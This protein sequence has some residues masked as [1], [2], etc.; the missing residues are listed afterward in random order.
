MRARA[1]LCALA[2]L[3][4]VAIG[5]AAQ[6]NM[7]DRFLL[8]SG[9][10]FGSVPLETDTSDEAGRVVDSDAAVAESPT[11]N[12]NVGRETVDSDDDGGMMAASKTPTV[13]VNLDDDLEPSAIAAVSEFFFKEFLKPGISDFTLE[14]LGNGEG[15]DPGL[16]IGGNAYG[17]A[18]IIRGES[19]CD[20]PQPHICGCFCT[21]GTICTESGCLPPGWIYWGK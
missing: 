9:N 21:G 18:L 7:I 8:T 11:S 4:S 17:G 6:G 2:V 3:L 14:R 16:R 10:F 15:E 12:P 13:V 5:V 1:T 19:L 20:H